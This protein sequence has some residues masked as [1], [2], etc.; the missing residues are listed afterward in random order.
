ME[1]FIEGS[2][3]FWAK[4]LLWT[5]ILKALD[6]ILRP[7]MITLKLRVVLEKIWFSSIF[8]PIMCVN[9]RGFILR[10]L[11]II[12][13]IGTP[14]SFVVVKIE[15]NVFIHLFNEIYLQFMLLMSEG[16]KVLQLTIPFFS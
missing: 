6:Y 11:V 7:P 15:I 16:T 14:N 13:W 3:S 1:F 4:V 12:I 2:M 8:L 5:S 9:T 10:N